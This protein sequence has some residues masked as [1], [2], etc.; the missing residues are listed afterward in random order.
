M[1]QVQRE[2]IHCCICFLSAFSCSEI[3]LQS[4]SVTEARLSKFSLQPNRRGTIGRC[5]RIFTGLNN[6][7]KYSYFDLPADK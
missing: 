7:K 2:E 4:I 6:L 1:K 3:K 5:W